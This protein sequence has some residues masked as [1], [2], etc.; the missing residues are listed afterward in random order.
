MCKTGSFKTFKREEVIFSFHS[1]RKVSKRCR[2]FLPISS[3]TIKT[4]KY[5]PQ[6]I[7]L[8][9]A[10]CHIPVKI[11]IKKRFSTLLGK[12]SLFPPNGI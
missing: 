5:S 12:E 9:L 4:K 3:N 2:A 8:K 10:P 6:R 11:Q 1:G 7:K